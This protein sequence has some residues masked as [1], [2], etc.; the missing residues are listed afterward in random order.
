MGQLQ[1]M[2]SKLTAGAYESQQVNH[3]AARARPLLEDWTISGGTT[4]ASSCS[5]AE[6]NIRRTA[7]GYDTDLIPNGLQAKQNLTI[8]KVGVASS[9]GSQ[10]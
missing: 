4:S 6:E 7:S 1:K 3:Q 10:S 9:P 5:Q 2:T 8:I